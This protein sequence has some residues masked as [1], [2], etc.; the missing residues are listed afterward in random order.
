M[1]I[2]HLGLSCFIIKAHETVLLL[3]PFSPKSVGLP[4]TT[5]EADMVLYSRPL[6]EID[7][8]TSSRTRVSSRRAELGKDLLVMSEPGEYEVG[9][10]LIQI[11]SDPEVVLINIEDVNICYI[12]MGKKLST[13]VD[14][15][16]LPT[17]DYLVVP[18]GDSSLCLDWKTL[19]VVLREME[20][21][22]VIPS[23]YREEG[24]NDP[25]DKLKTLDDFAA[26][27]GAGEVRH[28]KKLNL[29]NVIL[30]EEEK[31][32][33]IALDSK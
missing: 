2:K 26:E 5:E 19:E 25:F 11:H 27:F 15:E 14:F 17:I 18:V 20:A 31:Y 13:E 23:C 21:G 12:G 10:I 29:Q 30:G 6:S 16:S 32:E 28:E 3:D 9:G 24:M 8:Q 1:T 7:D 4:L 22:V 33:V